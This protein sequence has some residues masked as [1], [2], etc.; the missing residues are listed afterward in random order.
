MSVFLIIDIVMG[1]VE[2]IE[3]RLGESK[4]KVVVWSRFI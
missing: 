4:M 3:G 2:W 1:V